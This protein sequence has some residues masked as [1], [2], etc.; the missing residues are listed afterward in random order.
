MGCFANDRREDGCGLLPRRGRNNPRKIS[1]RIQ[2]SCVLTMV[3]DI[4]HHSLFGLGPSSRAE[5][6]ESE[7]CVSETDCVSFLKKTGEEI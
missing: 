7:Y 4:E 5:I 3:C 1:E 2:L 6:Q